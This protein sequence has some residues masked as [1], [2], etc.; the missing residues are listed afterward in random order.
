MLEKFKF[1]NFMP[2]IDLQNYAN[3][4][5]AQFLKRLP[6]GAGVNSLLERNGRLYSCRVDIYAKGGPFRTRV[7]APDPVSALQVARIRILRQLSKN[8]RMGLAR[9]AWH[10]I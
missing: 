7:T 1:R 5:V 9:L 3:T 6:Q 2:S 10:H 4:I 8:I